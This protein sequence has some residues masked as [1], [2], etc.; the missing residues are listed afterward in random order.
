MEYVD[1]LKNELVSK[2]RKNPSYSQRAFAKHL[3]LSPGE[4]SE[5]L[6]QKRALSLKKGIKVSKI[7]ELSPGEEESFL[8]SIQ[9]IESKRLSQSLELSQDMYSVLSD[10]IPFAIINLADCRDFQWNT[11]WISK[12]L[13]VHTYEVEL[14][15]ERLKRVGL[16]RLDKGKLV[17]EGDFIVAPSDVPS[18]AVRKYHKTMLEK[19]ITSLE[20]QNIEQRDITGIGLATTYE[21]IPQIKEEISQFLDQLIVKYSEKNS[22]HVYQLET[23]LFEIT[24]EAT[25]E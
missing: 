3:K 18:R 14:A 8:L 24:K 10:Y 16:L 1:I 13:G 22:N 21:K 11:Q 7:L 25:D 4:L 9:G 2:L 15:I 5:I 20:E 12:K 19:A 17:I 23:A 6:N